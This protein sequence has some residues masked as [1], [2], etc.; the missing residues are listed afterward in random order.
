MW[1][2]VIT[3]APVCLL[4]YLFTAWY[5]RQRSRR[6]E[7][8]AADKRYVLGENF[9]LKGAGT[10]CLWGLLY[11]IPSLS[12][13]LW[14]WNVSRDPIVV[15]FVAVLTL[16]FLVLGLHG[17]LVSLLQKIQ[18]KGDVLYYRDSFGAKYQIAKGEI[19]DVRL[20]GTSFIISTEQKK[21]CIMGGFTDD[22]RVWRQL[23][24]WA[25]KK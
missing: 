22:A 5:L 2:I 14:A 7:C 3:I 19:K 25:P 10:G 20:T 17:F 4:A 16:P 8:Q 24:D 1:K 23:V 12:A 9:T 13:V 15:L 6:I 11:L 21:F 18:F